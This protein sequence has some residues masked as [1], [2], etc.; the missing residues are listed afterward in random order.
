MPFS[1]LFD[2]FSLSLQRYEHQIINQDMKKTLLTLVCLAATGLTVNADNLFKKLL[3]KTDAEV[4]EKLETAWNHFF[5]PGDLSLYEAD[6][7]KTVY[8]ESA[9]G[10][11]FI[12]DTGSND[13]RTEGMSYGM[14]ISVQL[15]HREEFDKIWNWSKRYMA[16]PENSP[17]DGFFCWQCRPDGTKFGGS[18]ASDGEVYYATALFLAAERW[19]EPQYAKEANEILQRTMDNDGE[20]TGVY[21]LYNRD[22][23]LITFVPD[24]VGHS[25]TDPSYQLPA[26]LDYWAKVADKDRKFWK[27]AAKAARE[28]LIASADPVTGLYPDYSNYDGTA[29]RW[30]HAAYDTSIYMY[31]AIRCAMNVGMD[32]YLTGKDKR[33]QTEVMARLLTTM[34]N[35]GYRHGHFSLDGKK[36]FGDYSKGMA[37]ANAVGAFALANSTKEHQALARELVQGLWDAKLPTG[38]Y[39][40]Y[41]GMVYFLSLLHVSGKFGL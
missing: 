2:L 35:D 30:P 9:D 37:G 8:Y 18:N 40:Y 19:N 21:N 16:Y 22:N 14:M 3:G 33:R 7:Q 34:R 13:V 23:G 24:R 10:L 26:F 39:R 5:T 11:A 31:D 29:Y 15:G 12:M 27:K 1:L 38:K 25:F 20:L 41:E 28:H 17:W 4:N 36:A 6:G 32:Y